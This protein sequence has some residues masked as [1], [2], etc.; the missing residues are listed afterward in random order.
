MPGSAGGSRWVARR[1]EG[2]GSAHTLCQLWVHSTVGVQDVGFG[3]GLI[4][5]GIFRPKRE[6]QNVTR[7]VKYSSVFSL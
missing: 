1:G 7:H 2:A 4:R 6:G 5:G 3:P